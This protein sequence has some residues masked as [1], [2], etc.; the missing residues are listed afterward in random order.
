MENKTSS[1]CFVKAEATVIVWRFQI[2]QDV[3]TIEFKFIQSAYCIYL[4]VF[5]VKDI[6][7][8]KERLRV[9]S[10]LLLLQFV[11]KKLITSNFG[12]LATLLSC[13]FCVSLLTDAG[14]HRMIRVTVK[15]HSAGSAPR[16]NL[17]HLFIFLSQMFSKLFQNSYLHVILISHKIISSV[18]SSSHTNSLTSMLEGNVLLNSTQPITHVI[19]APY[20]STL[21]GD[22]G[23]KNDR[24]I[25]LDILDACIMHYHK[26][27]LIH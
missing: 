5:K 1:S 16:S 13:C 24:Y 26:T 15:N 22:S 20:D 14:L 21:L 10:V 8:L 18:Y 7:Q 4:Y 23:K 2:H 6:I 19:C 12:I 11:Q 17:T 3:N 25:M 9:I 27:S